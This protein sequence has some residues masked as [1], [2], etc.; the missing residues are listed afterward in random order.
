MKLRTQN[1]SAPAF[2]SMQAPAV[3]VRVVRERLCHTTGN[4]KWET[5]GP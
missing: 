3:C 1:I 2:A 4:G 5:S